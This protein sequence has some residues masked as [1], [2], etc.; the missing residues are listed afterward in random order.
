[1][2]RF[3]RFAFP[4]LGAMILL[5]GTARAEAPPPAKPAAIVNGKEIP[6]AAVDRALKPIAKENRDKARADI[7]NFLVENALIDHYLELLKV[8]VEAKEVDAQL[9]TFK[10]EV[11]A[12][13]QDY[14]EVL[15][16]MDINETDLKREIHNQLRWDKFIAQ[17]ATEEKLKK[18]FDGSPE[19][20]DGSLVHARHILLNTEGADDKAKTAA[21]KKIQEIKVAVEKS[22]AAEAEKL[23]VAA[24]NLAKQTALNKI[25]NDAFATA[26]RTHSDCPSKRD[27]GDLPEFPRM[28]QMVEPFAKAAFSL[29]PFQISEPVASPFGYHLILVTGRKSGE[30]PEFDK[31]KPVVAD[32]YGAKLRD[33]VVEK[34]KADPNTKIEIMK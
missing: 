17:Q 12:A 27:G 26:A 18:L 31:V 13:K 25:A 19:I 5:A 20:F 9:E 10:K 22:I 8:T 33:A 30:K 21:L 29:K 34:M 3:T 24:D 16:K 28:G 14:A 15:T 32:V 6:A 7:V 23:P 1:M 11:A 4:A 2:Q